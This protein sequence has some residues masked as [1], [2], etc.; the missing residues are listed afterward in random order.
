LKLQF[1][2]FAIKLEKSWEH[3]NSKIVVDTRNATR[4]VK[5][6]RDKIIKT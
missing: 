1:G 6:N 3:K 4:N 2:V 5:S